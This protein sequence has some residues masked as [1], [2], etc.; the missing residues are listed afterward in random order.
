VQ[1]GDARTDAGHDRLAIEGYSAPIDETMRPALP[2]C[3]TGG[4]AYR[5]D[6]KRTEGL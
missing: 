3:T 5:R 6:A 2:A 1:P 4:R